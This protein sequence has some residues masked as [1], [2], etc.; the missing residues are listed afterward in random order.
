MRALS[1]FSLIFV[2][3]IFKKEKGRTHALPFTRLIS[4]N[5]IL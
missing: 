1:I 5:F 2:F 3:E 4:A